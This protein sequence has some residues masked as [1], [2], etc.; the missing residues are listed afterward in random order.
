MGPL[1]GI[2]V[3]DYYLIAKGEIKVADLYREDGAYQFHR[4]WNIAAL[5]ATIVGGLFSSIL[6]HLTDWLPAW[7]GTY[8]WFFGV[9]IGAGLYYPLSRLPVL[10]HPHARG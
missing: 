7:W 3:V 8:G 5:I 10:R 1:L 9:A 6:P 2:I 4:G